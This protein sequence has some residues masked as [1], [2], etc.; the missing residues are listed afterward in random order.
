MIRKH[1]VLICLA[2]SAVLI[3]IAAIIYPGGTLHDPNTVGFDWSKNFISNLFGK[4][5]LNGEPNRSRSWA[6]IG[7]AFHSVGNGL[8][9][10]HMARKFLIKHVALVLKIV[11]FADML[12]SFLI[13][14]PL[15]DIMVTLSSTFSLIGLFYITVFIL[16]TRLHLLK[17]F[18]IVC[19]LIFYFTLYLYGSGD[20]G[21]LA[22]MQKV[23]FV[24][25]MLLVLS[26][27]YLTKKE[28]F[29]TNKER[30]TKVNT[31]NH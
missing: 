30:A 19:L 15:H 5:A 21:F 25:S 29:V 1:A 20:W 14:T 12:F 23:S 16:R 24:S 8:F 26:L 27:E 10:L 4:T 13:V 17:I 11:G 18:C 7:M 6:I 3:G 31:T 9:F 22:I 28:D 2:L